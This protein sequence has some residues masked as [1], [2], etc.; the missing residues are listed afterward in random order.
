MNFERA[1]LLLH[2]AEGA[3]KYPNLKAIHD[4]ALEELAKIAT[5]DTEEAGEDEGEEAQED[6]GSQPG[7]PNNDRRV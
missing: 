1:A 2:V 3:L 6:D 4:A 5:S 7:N